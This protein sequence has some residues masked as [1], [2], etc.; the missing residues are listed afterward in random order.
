MA[1]EAV[2][3]HL[4]RKKNKPDFFGRQ[5]LMNEED[6][7]CGEEDALLIGALDLSLEETLALIRSHR[8]VAVP[9]HI[10]RGYGIVYALGFIPEEAGFKVVEQGVNDPLV[11]GMKC[12]HNSDAHELGA[13]S[14]RE[15]AL[16]A[17]DPDGVLTFLREG[18]ITA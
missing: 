2:K 4:P 12:I 7:L 9:A 18:R 3:S 1:S 14:E 10:N 5:L 13:V 11:K 17:K 15:N 6:Q 8:G 16:L